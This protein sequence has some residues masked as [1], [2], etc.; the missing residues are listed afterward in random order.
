M[1]NVC[2]CV[3]VACVC[4]PQCHFWLRIVVKSGICYENVCQSVYLS[5][6]CHTLELRLNGL[7]YQNMLLHHIIDD[8]LL[9][10]GLISPSWITLIHPNDCV[11][12]THP[13]TT[14]TFDQ[15]LRYI[16]KCCEMWDRCKLH[17]IRKSYTGFRLP[18]VVTLKYLESRNGDYF[19]SFHASR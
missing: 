9:S 5:I 8:V 10:W 2:T 1:Y 7:R 14:R 12:D 16:L 18:K 6:V 15:I 13:L 3:Y 4:L 11:K 17:G 19:V